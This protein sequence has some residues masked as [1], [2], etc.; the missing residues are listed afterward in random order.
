[1]EWFVLALVLMFVCGILWMRAEIT[2]AGPEDGALPGETMDAI[3]V[4]A[5]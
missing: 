2:S 3:A 1:M 5:D 4:D